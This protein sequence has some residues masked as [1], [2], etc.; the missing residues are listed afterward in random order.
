MD[1]L[2][3]LRRYQFWLL[4]IALIALGSGL[5]IELVRG[6]A[7]SGIEF[8]YSSALPDGSRIRVQVTGA[9][10]KPGVYELREGDRVVDALAAA[11]GPSDS[12]D[13]D[14]LN[15]ARRVRDEEQLI[16][17]TRTGAAS[18]AA[19]LVPGAKLDINSA[20]QQQ[21]DALPGIGE[22]Y[23]RRIVDSRKVDG[24]YKATRDL[25]DRKVLPAATFDQLRDLITVAP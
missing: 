25:V 20:S 21:L 15:L 22:A 8:A 24:P 19:T 9:V 6:G 17:P 3:W 12:A 13:P 18:S 7:P 2:A 1:A 10:T 16:V 4:G 5:V 14:S 23:S 11:G